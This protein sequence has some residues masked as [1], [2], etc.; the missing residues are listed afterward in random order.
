LAKLLIEGWNMTGVR[1]TIVM[2]KGN[3]EIYFVIVVMTERG[4]TFATYIKRRNVLEL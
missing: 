1:A 2:R 3:A 4:T